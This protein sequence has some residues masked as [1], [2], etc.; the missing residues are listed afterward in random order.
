LL[1]NVSV[2]VKCIVA[3]ESPSLLTFER[4]G[5]VD[6]HELAGQYAHCACHKCSKL[7]TRPSKSY[8]KTVPSI[9]L[10]AVVYFLQ[11]RHCIADFS[12]IVAGGAVTVFLYYAD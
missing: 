3:L 4:D 9:K 11:K 7:S 6:L 10:S 8:I 1:S 2:L 5:R 12:E